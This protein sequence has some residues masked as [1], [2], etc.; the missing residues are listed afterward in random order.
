[1]TTSIGALCEYPGYY[2]TNDGL[3]STNKKIQDNK[4][5]Q[6]FSY[7]V[8]AEARIEEYRDALL[9]IAHPA[10]FGFFGQKDLFVATRAMCPITI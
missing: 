10:G 7:V 6:T 1:M 8:Q 9:K 5:Y 3:L 4:F 2:S